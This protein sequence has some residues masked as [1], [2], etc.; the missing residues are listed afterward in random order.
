MDGSGVDLQ[1]VFENAERLIRKGEPLVAYDM[2]Q[3]LVEDHYSEVKLRQLIALALARTGALPTANKLLRDLHDE[4]HRDGETLGILAS[5]FKSLAASAVGDDMQ[6]E[7]LESAFSIYFE[8]YRLA[9]EQEQQQACCYTGINAATLACVTG[10]D[11]TSLDIARDVRRRCK[12]LQGDHEKSYWNQATLAESELLL[13]NVAEAKT[14]YAKAA[15]LTRGRYG[16]LSTTRRQARLLMNNLGKDPSEIEQLLAIP[17]VV[18]FS[19][20]MIDRPTRPKPRFP[21]SNEKIIADVIR[22]EVERLRPAVAYSSAACGADILFLE[23]VLEQGAKTHVFL[24]FPAGEFRPVSVDFLPS[25]EWGKRFESVLDRA[26]AVM[27]ASD[28]QAKGSALS[29]HYLS[30]IQIGMARLH[31]NALETELLALVVWDGERGD[32]PGGTDSFV[33]ELTSRSNPVVRIDPLSAETCDVPP[34][35][36]A[37]ET[38]D[39]SSDS[40]SHH[41]L[42][43]MLFADTVGYSRLTE[44]QISI[45]VEK[46]LGAIAALITKTRYPPI[47]KETAGDGFYFVFDSVSEAGHFALELRDL[48]TDTNWAECGLPVALALRIGL[49]C[50]PVFACSDPITGKPAYTGTHTVRT[51]RIE[52][53]TPPRQVY[54]SQAF[55]AI[56]AMSDEDDLL[57]EFVGRTQLAK[58]YG[59]MPLY[60][61]DRRAPSAD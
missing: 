40:Y 57:F 33:S 42:K 55:A 2:L 47:H 27:V 12:A 20:H 1:Q 5:T 6:S 39:I 14:A 15:T 17:P 30:L 18:V 34:S 10:R 46:F 61:V 44:D 16:D 45:Y 25:G 48:I 4:G 8:G 60:R 41:E 35:E 49:H 38:V 9:M 3:K 26:D 54:A 13:G 37:A 23:A 22:K 43:S 51:A 28:H 24:P 21:P 32:F 7:N 50:G 56:A 19:G 58:K 29:F 11:A 36:S 53:I 59:S 31:A 52:P